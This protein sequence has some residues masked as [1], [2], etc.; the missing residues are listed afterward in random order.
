MAVVGG[1]N[2][3]HDTCHG[4]SED[5]AATRG[6]PEARASSTPLQPEVARERAPLQPEEA[7]E[8][9]PESESDDAGMRVGGGGGG[10]GG[11][12]GGGEGCGGVGNGK[13]DC[14]GEECV[15]TCA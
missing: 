15:V 12:G 9:R 5:A 2:A 3:C 11:W 4:T 8:R 14:V 6:P 13:G 10:V 1:Q 7:R